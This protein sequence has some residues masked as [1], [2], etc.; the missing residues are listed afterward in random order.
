[1]DVKALQAELAA[2]AAERDWDATQSPRNLAIAL[3]AEAGGLLSLFKWLTDEQSQ[4]VLATDQWEIAADAVA[5]IVLHALALAGRAGIDIEAALRARL[6][7]NVAKYPMSGL[8]GDEAA[9]AVVVLDMKTAAEPAAVAPA[10]VESEDFVATVDDVA[11]AV[12]AEPPDQPAM[13]SVEAGPLVEA[14]VEPVE[15]PAMEEFIAEAGEEELARSVAEV[16]APPSDPGPPAH[17]ALELELLPVAP[18]GPV[19]TPSPAPAAPPPERYPNLDADAAMAL[20]KSLAK[21]LDH[22]RSRDPLLRELHDELETL[23]RTLYAPNVKRA[24]VAGSLKTVRGLLEQ[25]AGER[26]GEEIGADDH[27]LRIDGI[28]QE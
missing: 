9:E 16:S 22:A 28:L 26:F 18:R 7:R 11:E 8:E 13:E 17:A 5:A 19:A 27:I 10:R 3:A 25:A 24:W 14:V 4:E 21:K 1:M 23:K 2:F 12:E 20:A 15:A 6:A